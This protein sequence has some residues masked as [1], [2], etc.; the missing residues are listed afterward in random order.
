VPRNTTSQTD[1]SSRDVSAVRQIGRRLAAQIGTHKYDMWF[2]HTQLHVEGTR[3][4]VAT[5]SPFVAQWIGAHFADELKGAAREA[6]GSKARIDVRVAPELS[7]RHL[8]RDPEGPDRPPRGQGGR[9]EATLRHHRAPSAKRRDRRRAPSLRRLDEFIVGE[10][11]RLAYS[12]A[13]R[14][15]EDPE[16]LPISPLFVHGDC[17]V[18]KTHL[19][20]GICQHFAR[21]SDR[22]Q[23]VRY[24]TGEQFTNEYIAAIRA[25][26]IDGFRCRIRKL[27]LL[28]IDDI[29]FLSN[30]VRTQSEFLHTLDAIDLTG[31]RIVLASDEHPRLIKRFSQ[32]LI[33]R[34]LSGMVVRIDRPD[35]TT[36]LEIVKRLAATRRLRMS[37]AAIDTIASR[38]VGSVRELEGAVTKLAALHS[39]AADGTP[40]GKDRPGGPEAMGQE[41]GLVLTEQ[42]FK[43]HGW[44]PPTPVRLGTVIEMIC[45]RLAVSR[46]DLM[47]SSRH[48]R[49]VLG[50]AL[51]AYL[52]REM[53]THSYP[54]IAAGLGRS[55]HSTIHTAEQRLR[56]QMAEEHMVDLGEAQH[57]MPLKELVDQ[58]RHEI[59][60][61]TAK[62]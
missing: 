56:R 19:L 24:V 60:K 42:L 30:K 38:C 16:A 21:L 39:L 58:L 41:I 34:F 15:I 25:G 14:L 1:R 43:D 33:S 4:E 37:E 28:A 32:A 2:G 23:A 49:V 48:R 27:D 13:R 12:A 36:R 18:G 8:A 10:S 47:G 44:Q 45:Q 3:L 5:D 6:L 7:P 46:A 17:G 29:H 54:E 55:Y 50:R 20:Q 9:D 57:P 61:A 11:N 53:T 40:D 62:S 59:M 35:R 52:G 22:P 26:S 31:A 51:V